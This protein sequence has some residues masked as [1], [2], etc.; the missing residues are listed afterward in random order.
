MITLCVYH[1]HHS[2]NQSLLDRIIMHPLWI[3]EG[4]EAIDLG[5]EALE[6]WARGIYNLFVQD[7]PTTISYVIFLY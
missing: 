4:K 3:S 6:R 7:V 1:P 2:L 5:S